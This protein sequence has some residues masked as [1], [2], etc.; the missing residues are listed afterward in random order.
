MASKEPQYEEGDDYDED[1]EL[2][3]PTQ[4]EEVSF[5][6]PAPEHVKQLNPDQKDPDP[7]RTVHIKAC[8]SETNATKLSEP[9]APSKPIESQRESRLARANLF[10]TEDNDETRQVPQGGDQQD[11]SI[12]VRARVSRSSHGDPNVN[13][14]HGDEHDPENDSVY[15]SSSSEHHKKVLSWEDGD[16]FADRKLGHELVYGI[17][18]HNAVSSKIRECT[19]QIFACIHITPKLTPYYNPFGTTKGLH[20]TIQAIC[21][22]LMLHREHIVKAIIEVTKAQ[23][24]QARERILTAYNLIDNDGQ[25]HRLV[26][27]AIMCWFWLHHEKSNM[28]AAFRSITND[29][30][31]A[32]DDDT[33]K[34]LRQASSQGST[35]NLICP[36]H[37]LNTE[38]FPGYSRLELSSG[39][40]VERF[41]QVVLNWYGLW[42]CFASFACQ[43]DYGKP[44]LNHM[45]ELLKK[46]DIFRGGHATPEEVS[47]H[48]FCKQ[49]SII[50]LVAILHDRYLQIDTY[51]RSSGQEQRIPSETVRKRT[52]LTSVM[53]N[54]R[55]VY[56]RMESRILTLDVD[57]D[58]MTYS[59]LVDF[60][61]KAD[62]PRLISC[63]L[64]SYAKTMNGL[65]EKTNPT[66]QPKSQALDAQNR[67]NYYSPVFIKQHGHI[68]EALTGAPLWASQEERQDA[69]S[70]GQCGNCLNYKEK[71]YPHHTDAHC[72]FTLPSCKP[73]TGPGPFSP[74]APLNNVLP[75]ASDEETIAA[76]IKARQERLTKGPPTSPGGKGAKGGKS[77]NSTPSV[78]FQTMQ[79][80]SPADITIQEITTPEPP[81]VA[82]TLPPSPWSGGGR[83]GLGWCHVN[84]VVGLHHFS[85][86]SQDPAYPEPDAIFYDPPWPADRGTPI[87]VH[88]TTLIPTEEE[89]DDDFQSGDY[90][91]PLNNSFPI[92]HECHRSTGP[93]TDMFL[94][95]IMGTPALSV[96]G[97]DTYAGTSAIS[98]SAVAKICPYPEVAQSSVILQ[99]V[100]GQC[101]SPGATTIQVRL[102]H[103]WTIVPVTVCI[104]PDHALPHGV[105]I[106]FGVQFQQHFG[107][108]IDCSNHVIFSTFHR[109][110]IPLDAL[111]AIQRRQQ[112]QPLNILATCSGGSFVISTLINLGYPIA[113]WYACE[114]DRDCHKVAKSLIPSDIYVELGDVTL[115]QPLLATTWIDIHI[116]TPPC[117][118]WSQLNSCPLGFKDVRA[119]VFVACSQLH[120]QLSRI[121]PNIQVIVENVKPHHSLHDDLD[122]MQQL[123]Q[124]PA[125]EL[126]ALDFGSISR[127]SRIIITNVT[128]SAELIRRTRPSE[129]NRFV[130]DY[131]WYCPSGHFP[132]IV[133]SGNTL[134][135]PR[136]IHRETHQSRTLH[137]N[138]SE[139]AQGLPRYVTD[140]FDLTPAQCLRMIGN[141]LNLWMMWPILR[142]Y[143]PSLSRQAIPIRYISVFHST[144][145]TSPTSFPNTSAGADAYAEVLNALDDAALF[146]YFH[147]QCSGFK[148]SELSLQLRPGTG[149]YAKPKFPYP[150]PSGLVQ[151]THYA[152]DQQVAHGQL[153]ELTHINDKHW[154]SNSFVKE[155]KGRVWPGTTIPLVRILFDLRALNSCLLPAPPHWNFASPDQSSMCQFIP[156][157]TQYMLQCDLSNA[158]STATIAKDSRNLLVTQILG[159]YFQCVGGPQGLA[160]MALFWN[161]HLQEAFYAALSIHW[162]WWWTTFVDDCGI[163]GNSKRAVRMRSRILSILLD[164]LKKPHAFGNN[165]DGT[166]QMEP[167][168]SM[169]LAGIN[170]TPQG[171]S[172]ATDQ[173]DVLRFAL[174][175]YKVRTKQDAQHVIG[176][177]QYCHTAFRMDPDTWKLYAEALHKLIDTANAV[178]AQNAKVDWYPT[179]DQA[180]LFLE[181]LI[182]SAPRAMWNPD[183]ILDDNQCIAALSD[184]SD[185]AAGICLYV[186]NEPNA[187]LITEEMLKDREKSQLIATKLHKFSTSQ[188]RWAVFEKEMYGSVLSVDTW[189]NFITTATSRFAIDSSK[190]KIVFFT[191]STTTIAKWTK[192]HVPDG[193]LK[194]LCSKWRRFNNWVCIVAHTIHW[195]LVVK[196]IP[197][198]R[199]SL[200]H[201]LSH[202]GHLIQSRIELEADLPMMIHPIQ[203]YAQ[204]FPVAVVSYYNDDETD[205]LRQST[206]QIPDHF[207]IQ[208]IPFT[209]D[210]CIELRRAYLSDPTVYIA[211]ITI[212]QIY[213]VMTQPVHDVPTLE[214]K[215]ISSWINRLFFLHSL[216][217]TDLLLTQ[218][219][220]QVIRNGT[221]DVP[222][223]DQTNTLVMVLPEGAHLQISSLEPI[224]T[225]QAP[226]VTGSPPLHPADSSTATYMQYDLIKDVMCYCHQGA[227]HPSRPQT[228]RNFKSI[229]WIPK[230][231]QRINSFIDACSLCIAKYTPQPAIGNS[232]RCARRFSGVQMDHKVFDD[233]IKKVTL[234]AGCL[235]IICET[236]RWVKFAPVKTL[237]ALDAA[238]VFYTEWVALFGVPAQIRSDKG[239]AFIATLMQAV[240]QILGIK[241]HDFACAHEPTHHALVEKRHQ[242]LDD[243]LND[244]YNKGDLSQGTIR[245]YCAVAEQRHNQYTH[246]KHGHTPFELVTGE[247]PRH[248]HNF[249]TIPSIDAIKTLQ[250]DDR[251]FVECLRQDIRNTI[252]W[253][254]LRDD[255]RLHKEK[256]HRLTA[257]HTRQ[258][259]IFDL[260]INDIVSFEGQSAT[261]LELIQP[262]VTG[263][264][265]ARI[266]LTNHDSSIDKIVL[267]ADLLP[268]GIAY[269]ELMIDTPLVDI[270]PGT[271]CFYKY[272]TFNNVD[273]PNQTIMICAGSIISCNLEQ[274]QC[275]VH[276]YQQDRRPSTKYK[277]LY[278]TKKP[279]TPIC[280][281]VKC[282]DIV[283][284][285]TLDSKSCIPSETLR[286]LANHGTMT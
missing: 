14:S 34:R 110:E 249:L 207:V 23:G 56:E 282:T 166:W 15:S 3:D 41:Q 162:K 208:M 246:S 155:K 24:S 40:S 205:A 4:E 21:N 252:E 261:I 227:H 121:N 5:K 22:A 9:S 168:T 139:V 52:L 259:K 178:T 248:Q 33:I 29:Y 81:R 237:G 180:C 181:S 183:T 76:F 216:Q 112:C 72:P 202:M 179:C 148:P 167:Q 120:Q 79:V 226:D 64:I 97:V 50:E 190:P 113:K 267:Y 274:N 209:A 12:G 171:F 123:W 35:L 262:T 119:Q 245:Y 281:E 211:G 193:N 266:R 158:F 251:A 276:C 174:R 170:V 240:A 78:T 44:R 80:R 221:S 90:P 156:R 256:A 17:V 196:Y 31:L 270:H 272:S 219:S 109:G 145:H 285:P 65:H 283:I 215:R 229:A 238:R 62:R 18:G 253:T 161:P 222:A 122:R 164:Y 271:F 192:L 277:P 48:E 232:T 99:G 91:S 187:N 138:E 228:I 16:L 13:N 213:K 220:H 42:A 225:D 212:S 160:N 137:L 260:R 142:N 47:A 30:L 198:E 46:F 96:A 197:G 20:T 67:Q 87:D 186:V 94:V 61:S 214:T 26:I 95:H 85:V 129:P 239:S 255:D 86:K 177:I 27:Y 51:A 55:K 263:H 37:M 184:A 68:Y 150:V 2:Y 230:L 140:G 257:L 10:N 73:R 89:D 108:E 135:P 115:H 103:G 176:V 141:A 210:D 143:R 264:A 235:S 200:T 75:V 116:A 36:A 43:E 132:C 71:R 25:T 7:Q 243:I 201:M 101:T 118:P 59:E 74:V 203:I 69:I 234:H 280:R 172:I 57:L 154:I 66:N 92:P 88:A 163:F 185:T 199:I 32:P 149:P 117:Q 265:K 258:H 125:I 206:Q 189:G 133:A 236:S 144:L 53:N 165:K 93:I 114:T 134:N 157:D 254:H 273:D 204:A 224:C 38:Q 104:L 173:L 194:N 60:I 233:D 275:T 106:L 128:S 153:T 82:P 105:D 28:R 8:T 49:R 247:I 131:S 19:N 241:S 111:S 45:E 231:F 242:D 279:P 152:L 191:D 159:R 188:Q 70:K 136:V 268:I 146:S 84:T 244:A 130:D 11:E 6:T 63:D 77:R 195:P 39:Q 217:D 278:T 151:A 223:I 58:E 175:E 100:G 169:I 250:P 126:Q 98:Q 286:F 1:Y 284:T 127:R 147:Q 218:S 269:P 182:E 124:C 102:Q 54:H 107:L 83:G